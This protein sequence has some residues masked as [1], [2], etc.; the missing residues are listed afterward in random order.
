L[1]RGAITE[2]HGPHSSGR[3]TLLSA[4][5]ADATQHDE[6]CAIVDTADTFDPVS[7][8][9][10]G[11]LLDRVLWVRCGGNA[12]LAMRVMDLILQSGGFGIVVM[13][14]GDTAPN[15]ARR[16]SLASWYR[17]RRTVEQTRTVM[18]VVGLEPYARQCASLTLEASRER[19][20]WI[21]TA[22][23]SRVLE[24]VRV[25]VDRRKPVG[26]ATRT[27]LPVRAIG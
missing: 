2:I 11:V 8:D 18:I 14:L 20:N 22:G 3:T 24:Q 12:E 27:S 19:L 16:I 15:T 9:A 1:P 4:I 6:V 25:R 21:G 5:L 17:Y 13:D 10:A 23:C 26:S 7:A